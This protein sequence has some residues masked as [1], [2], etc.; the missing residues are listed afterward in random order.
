MSEVP[1]PS[2]RV[3]GQRPRRRIG[4]GVWIPGGIG[5]RAPE[6]RGRNTDNNGGDEGSHER[7]LRKTGAAKNAAFPAI[8]LA[9][10]RELREPPRS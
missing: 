3:E 6:E 4:R 7:F 10:L 5:G 1:R 8:F 2:H 9:I